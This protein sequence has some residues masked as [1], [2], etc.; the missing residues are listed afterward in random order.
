MKIAILFSYL[1]FVAVFIG[2]AWIWAKKKGRTIRKLRNPSDMQNFFFSDLRKDFYVSWQFCLGLALATY[3][4]S[5]I[6][7]AVVG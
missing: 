3:I 5:A 6:Y 2:G 4:A 7:E 1:I